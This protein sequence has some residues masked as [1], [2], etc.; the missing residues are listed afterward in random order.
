MDSAW[1]GVFDRIFNEF[2]GQ[3]TGAEK[4]ARSA[5]DAEIE[6]ERAKRARVP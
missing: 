1:A 5:I 4:R 2:G 6:L 3:P